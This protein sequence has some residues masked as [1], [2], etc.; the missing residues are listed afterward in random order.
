MA[1]TAQNRAGH[2]DNRAI[3]DLI[4]F[5]YS[6][7]YDLSISGIDI[8]KVQDTENLI[9]RVTK[10]SKFSVQRISETGNTIKEILCEM[11]APRIELGT[12]AS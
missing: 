9:Q 6:K 8:R 2:P 10:L 12:Y 4:F 1:E 7:D 3:S 5:D 11:A